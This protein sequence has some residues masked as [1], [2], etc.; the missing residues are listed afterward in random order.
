MSPVPL[1]PVSVP[2]PPAAGAG[3]SGGAA[4]G[5]SSFFGSPALP[6]LATV[7]PSAGGLPALMLSITVA[8]EIALAKARSA[9]SKPSRASRYLASFIA[10]SASRMVWVARVKSAATS[11]SALASTALPCFVF[12]AACASLARSRTLRLSAAVTRTRFRVSMTL[13][14]FRAA[15]GAFRGSFRSAT[16][17]SKRRWAS[18]K[19]SGA[20]TSSLRFW[21]SLIAFSAFFI[22][23]AAAVRAFFRSAARSM[24]LR[25]VWTADESL[26][27][28][29]SAF[30]ESISS[31][32]SSS[33]F[34]AWSNS[35]E[36][37]L[38]APE[39]T[40]SSFRS[41][42]SWSFFPAISVFLSSPPPEGVQEDR[43][44]T[45]AKERMI[46]K[47]R[48]GALHGG[49]S[50]CP[51]RRRMERS[52]ITPTAGDGTSLHPCAGSSIRGGR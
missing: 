15:P 19:S 21:V 25:K 18:W 43:R 36:S 51:R 24:R 45:E 49:P 42:A 3:G 39:L 50:V 9:C 48:A 11:L 41:W 35:S 27:S 32:A 6:A 5:G 26:G 16:A 20:S 17:V 38:S 31:L 2:S 23:S 47:G 30:F 12:A 34:V 46:R 44:A 52:H 10:S 13:S 37:S 1:P 33:F 8:W 29:R 7:A 40:A 28:A 22:E 14:N 4:A